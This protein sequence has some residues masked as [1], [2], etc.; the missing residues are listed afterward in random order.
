MND[1]IVTLIITSA[2]SL[3]SLFISIRSYIIS[4]P[5]LKINITD[6]KSDVYYGN[7]CADEDEKVVSTKIGSVSIN[8]IN[9]SPVD[10]SIR[11]IK[12][13]IGKNLHRLV[14][15]NN[16]Y[17]EFCYFFYKDNN[18]EKIWDGSGINYKEMGFE[19]PLKINSYS[20]QS[21]ICLFHDFPNTQNK[22]IKGTIIL[23]S[24]VG[25]IKKKIKFIQYDENYVSSEMKDVELYRKNYQGDNV[26]NS[27]LKHNHINKKR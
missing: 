20:I 26:W 17:W 25:K 23:Y 15:K 8:I 4:K 27:N 19:L 5:K 7:V 11:D 1:T 22:K 3:I 21:G 14:F 2:I 12:L 24:A 16:P 18:N 9:N 13:R 6:K 10:I